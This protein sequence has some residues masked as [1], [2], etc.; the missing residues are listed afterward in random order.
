MYN[1]EALSYEGYFYHILVLSK[2]HA[3]AWMALCPV[4]N[5][6]CSLSARLSSTGYNAVPID[7][8][9]QCSRLSWGCEVVTHPGQ[10]RKW[11]VDVTPCWI[12]GCWRS[13]LC[14]QAMLWGS[15]LHRGCLLYAGGLHTK[16]KD[17][18]G[19]LKLSY[20]VFIQHN[21]THIEKGLNYKKKV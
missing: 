19:S 12:L 20:S 3:M 5:T 10:Y 17:A 15:L 11:E 4:I 18:K 8:V 14:L 7:A 2:R 1:L 16:L 13:L 6:V 21:W 9:C